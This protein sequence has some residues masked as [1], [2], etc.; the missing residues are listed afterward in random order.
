MITRVTFKLQTEKKTSLTVLAHQ[1][2][3]RR[4]V[5]PD[6]ILHWRTVDLRNRFLLLNVIKHNRS[7]RAEN[8]AGSATVKDFICLNGWLDGF[9]DGI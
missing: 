8:E 4:V 6:H 9:D 2:N 7:C 1:G 3:Q 5:T